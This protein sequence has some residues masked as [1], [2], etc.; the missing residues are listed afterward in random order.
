VRRLDSR[1]DPHVALYACT[2]DPG[3]ARPITPSPVIDRCLSRHRRDY[4][5]LAGTAKNFEELIRDL[6]T[7]Q[8]SPP[9]YSA[10]DLARISV[11]VLPSAEFNEFIYR[12]QAEYLAGPCRMPSSYF[13]SAK[14]TL[15]PSN[16]P[17]EFD[18]RTLRF[19]SGGRGN[20]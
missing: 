12:E 6:G 2:M 17:G 7:M 13:C 18:R 8:R 20:A 11:P 19:L 1:P 9:D 5:E 10:L 15:L 14:A 3:G 16:S 4:A